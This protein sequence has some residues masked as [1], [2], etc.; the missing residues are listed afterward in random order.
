MKRL[1][2]GCASDVTELII[3][4]INKIK[5]DKNRRTKVRSCISA[6]ARYRNSNDNTECVPRWWVRS[7]A[8][9]EGKDPRG[10]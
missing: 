3:D 6:L 4:Q 5:H 7:I 10:S 1:I 9:F 2:D 8:I